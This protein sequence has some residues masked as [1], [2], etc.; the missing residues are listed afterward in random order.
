MRAVVVSRLGGPDVLQVVEQPVPEPGPGEVRIR[1]AAASVNFADVKARYGNY[2]HAGAPPFVPGLDL[3]GTVDAVGEG[4]TGLAVG[5]RVMAFPKGGAYSEYAVA[6]AVLAYPV[7][8]GVDLETAAALA[9][10]GVTAYE[11]LTKVAR[12][13]PGETVLVHAAAGGVGTVAL[14]L[15]KILGA[16][17]VIGTVGSDEKA[18]HA[19][20]YGA[21]V[22]INYSAGGFADAVLAATDGRGA[23]VI[24]DAVG[25]PAFAD[26]LRCLARFGR[27]VVYGNAAGAYGQVD[28]AELHSTC[29]SVLGYSM[30]TTR[31]F[32]PEALRAS[33]ERV[34]ELVATGRLQVPVCGR[35]PLERAAE[36]HTVMENRGTLGKVLLV[37]A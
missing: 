37:M 8:D 17:Q 19:R 10:V 9:T 20:R 4:V 33:A 29:R 15:A 16:G 21:D 6:P 13:Q 14:Q 24:L 32:R 34:L 30:G 3:A 36:A 5:Q 28:T 27:L 35:Y 22:V 18:E 7:P 2:H 25:G 26:N 12:L 1:V 11:L 23:D 31:R